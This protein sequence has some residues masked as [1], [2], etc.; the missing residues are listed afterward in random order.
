MPS[1][2]IEN[3]LQ[4]VDHFLAGVF[5]FIADAHLKATLDTV[6]CAL[7]SDWESRCGFPKRE[8]AGHAGQADL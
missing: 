8:V 1:G 6:Q 4:A 2:G 7:N 3:E 5:F